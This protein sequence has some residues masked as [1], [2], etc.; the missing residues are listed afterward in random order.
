MTND[1]I[2]VKTIGYV[3][4]PVLTMNTDV[5]EVIAKDVL[6]APESAA[7]LLSLSKIVGKGFSVLFTPG[8]F[9]IVDNKGT[10]LAMK[11]ENG[12]YR[13]DVPR[14]K[15]YFAAGSPNAEL[16]HKR[17]GHLSY[18][19]VKEFSRNS[20]TGVTINNFEISPC[21]PC[22]KRKQHRQPFSRSKI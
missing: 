5:D 15:V 6:Y 20:V 12:I 2:F 16:W 7:N 4:I 10:C 9:Y 1:V 14:E 8:D 18:Q 3:K 13:L 22:I 11:E 19:G 17:L 21:E